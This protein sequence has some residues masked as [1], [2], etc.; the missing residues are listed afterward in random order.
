[1]YRKFLCISMLLIGCRTFAGSSFVK[2]PKKNKPSHPVKKN[3]REILNVLLSPR[4]NEK[5][6]EYKKNLEKKKSANKLNKLE[7][8]ALNKAWNN[9]PKNL[10]HPLNVEKNKEKN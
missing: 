6:E 9:Y 7:Q 4:Y 8:I 10:Q 3:T 1:M 2:P 5:F